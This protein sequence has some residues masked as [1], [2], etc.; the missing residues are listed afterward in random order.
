MKKLIL[1][2]LYFF[3]SY[4]LL[5]QDYCKKTSI[6]FDI[7]KFELESES[8]PKIDSL[9]STFKGS[10]F[11]IEL[12][13]YSDSIAS[14]EYNLLL[15]QK[16]I[17]SVKTYI[18]SKNN[19]KIKF[20]EKNLGEGESDSKLK[21]L[22][23]Y[24]RVDI[25]VFPLSNGKLTLANGRENIEVESDYFEPC[26]IC[27]SKPKVNT[28]YT[29]VEANRA[30]I[31]FR[32]SEGDKL[33]SAGTFNFNFKPC[34]DSKKI[35]PNRPYCLTVQ[36]RQVDRDM[37]VWEP[38]TINGRIYWKESTVIPEFDTVNNTYRI[39]RT[40]RLCNLDK[41][42]ILYLP[43]CKII[44]PEDFDSLKIEFTNLKPDLSIIKTHRDTTV[45]GVLPNSVTCIARKNNEIY[46]TLVNLHEIKS[47]KE[48][49]YEISR[50]KIVDESE[51]HID[52][53]YFTK[54]TFSD[55]NYRIKF[56]NKPEKVGFYILSVNEFIP[57]EQISPNKDILTKIPIGE[58]NLAYVKKNK[59]YV[60]P[61]KKIKPRYKKK[62]NY[63][64]IKFNS[65]N[66]ILFKRNKKYYSLE[67]E[68]KDYCKNPKNFL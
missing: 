22:S 31:E 21:D 25:F 59:I 19:S 3:A 8:I 29:E 67:Q 55:T 54:F 28:Y 40:G 12:Y 37:K 32:T 57:I 2:F 53:S 36:A 26:G 61:Y 15:S 5:A 68:W 27:Q 10:D 30:G 62:K 7:N 60:I 52:S 65:K 11:L 34:D 17:N 47:S 49:R 66:I 1:L 42:D 41:F 18:T 45:F 44:F 20:F 16:R 4:Q 33:I 9:I 39:C 58:Y 51:F 64:K 46:Y 38:D 23:L 43:S 24:R 48:T 6:Y 13:G 50:T 63:Y 35:A 14:Q 56:K